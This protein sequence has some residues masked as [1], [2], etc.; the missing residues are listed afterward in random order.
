MQQVVSSAFDHSD[1]AVL[2]SGADYPD[3]L[4]ALALAGAHHA[5]VVL[6]AP[7]TLSPQAA[8]ELR[9]LGCTNLVCVGGPAAVSDAVLDQARGI[10]GSVTRVSGDSR[11]E[12][13]LAAFREARAASSA[14]DTVILATGGN[15]AD[16]LSA[17]PWSWRT[18]APVV[19]VKPDGTLT[20][21]AV[22]QIRSDA[23]IKRV[24]IMGG[25]AAVSE[26]VRTQLGDGYEYVRLAGADRYQTSATAAQWFSGHGLNWARPYVATGTGFADALAAA[27]VAGAGSAPLVLVN[28]NSQDAP[29]AISAHR[30]DIREV[31]IVGGTSAVGASAEGALRSALR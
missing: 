12:T 18:V 25:E 7:D 24:V 20:A 4:S 11:Y 10:V 21:E 19:L 26:S 15:F 23:G 9:R 29:S 3:A 17:G 5:P 27:A 14:S 1:W 28:P 16:A 31:T 2:A 30:E 13:S 8:E 22:E 6:T